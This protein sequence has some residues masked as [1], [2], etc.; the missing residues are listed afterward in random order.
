MKLFQIAKHRS[1]FQVL[2]STHS[3]QAAVMVLEPGDTSG[4][5]S[6]EHPRSEQWLFVVSGAGR[7]RVGKR[8]ASLKPG[9]L[10]LIEK[11]EVHQIRSTG[12]SPLVTLNIYTPPAYTPG[13]EPR[14]P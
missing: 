8:S 7:A 3:G 4:P 9:V 10:L 12:R 11:R 14:E 13:G 5:P 1:E 2:A 6:N